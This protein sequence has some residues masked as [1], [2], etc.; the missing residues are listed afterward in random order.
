MSKYVLCNCDDSTEV[1]H[2]QE[3]M[4]YGELAE[5]T[6][7]EQVHRFGFCTCED[8]PNVY[9]DCPGDWGSCDACGFVYELSDRVEHCG[10]C[11]TCWDH[12]SFGKPHYDE[13]VGST[14]VG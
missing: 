14:H 3:S 1:D 13:E 7:A 10:E 2:S 5:L 11:G 12:C 6:H 9:D 8:G 4:S